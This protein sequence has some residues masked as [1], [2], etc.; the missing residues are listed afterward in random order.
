MYSRGLDSVV[1]P[2]ISLS[3]STKVL[4]VNEQVIENI[5]G[6]QLGMKQA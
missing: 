4:P 2:Q 5:G 6:L 3:F 1:G